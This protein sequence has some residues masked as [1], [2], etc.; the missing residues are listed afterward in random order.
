MVA[1]TRYVGENTCYTY[2]TDIHDSIVTKLR[3]IE[4]IPKADYEVQNFR[5]FSIRKLVCLV[6][7]HTDIRNYP[8]DVTSDEIL[9]LLPL[10]WVDPIT[11][12]E[13]WG[14]VPEPYTVE[15]QE[16]GYVICH[17]PFNAVL[18]VAYPD[19]GE[20]SFALAHML[21]G[22]C[23]GDKGE[24]CYRGQFMNLRSSPIGVPLPNPPE[25]D[26]AGLKRPDIVSSRLLHL[27]YEP[28][29]PLLSPIYFNQVK[30]LEMTWLSYSD[31]VRQFVSR[32]S[33]HLW[34]GIRR[35]ELHNLVHHN[36]VC[37]D[38]FD[39]DL[40]DIRRCF[41]E[42]GAV[43]SQVLYSWFSDYQRDCRYKETED[44]TRD[45]GFLRYLLGQLASGG[46]LIGEHAEVAGTYIAFSFLTGV[47]AVSAQKSG[48][49]CYQFQAAVDKLTT[50]TASIVNF[51]C[52]DR[53]TGVHANAS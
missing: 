3:R 22:G 26:L 28:G 9:A 49:E 32:H 51:L 27:K 38:D 53:A 25:I 11:A 42:L 20:L 52:S 44:S 24:I 16:H 4:G 50:Y 35:F 6:K 8:D 36:M 33:T 15:L 13:K 19:I 12:V 34:S 29:F 41:P 10:A 1:N 37:V 7:E 18:P 31:C 46:R 5:V 45:D 23:I 2:K 21:V 47:G 17:R 43:P 30:S 14:V 39:V 40:A 48:L